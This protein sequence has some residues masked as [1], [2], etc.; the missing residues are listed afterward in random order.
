MCEFTNLD[1]FGTYASLRTLQCKQSSQT[2]TLKPKT[3]CTLHTSFTYKP[4]AT[5]ERK[6]EE[7]QGVLDLNRSRKTGLRKKNKTQASNLDRNKR[8]HVVAGCCKG[9]VP[10]ASFEKLQRDC[11][12]PR[13]SATLGKKGPSTRKRCRSILRRVQPV[14]GYARTADTIFL[15][16]E[17]R[18]AH[19]ARAAKKS[20]YKQATR[21]LE[22]LRYERK[23]KSK[24]ANFPNEAMVCKTFTAR[25]ETASPTQAKNR[26]FRS[27]VH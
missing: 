7:D 18:L 25:A 15:P 13:L 3:A 4:S 10:R 27:I 21:K 23:T 22:S 6:P 1:F 8:P 2:F 16:T 5:S 9:C 20:F 12:M 24:V 19:E 26:G 17:T 11:S 14:S